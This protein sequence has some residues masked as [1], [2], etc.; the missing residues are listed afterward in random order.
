MSYLA[1]G[2]VTKSIAELLAKKMKP[3]LLGAT[4]PKVTTLPPDDERVD[5][6]D[7]VNLFLY[8]VSEDPYT[9]NMDWRGNRSNAGARHPALSLNLYYLLTGYAK[10]SN[11]SAQDDITAHQLLGNA[12]AI[13]NEYP[14]LNDIHDGDFDADI[15]AQFAK[16]LRDSFERIKISLMPNSMDEFS[17]I[18]TGLS[19]AY[20]LSVTY[21]VSLV[22]IAPTVLSTVNQPS[23]QQVS[24][25]VKA[26][27]APILA[28]ITPSIGT[29]GQQVTLKGKGFLERGLAT[30][31]LI[32]DLRVDETDLVSLSDDQIVLNIPAA[33]QR[34]PRLGISVLVGTNGSEAQTYEV[35]PWIS[36][37]QPLRGL[38]G[39]PLTF[40][41][42]VPSGATIEAAIDGAAVAITVDAEKQVVRAIV[43]PGIVTNGP[44][45]VALILNTKH[46]NV[47]F[48]EVLP[49]ITNV[50]VTTVAA[51]AKTTIELTG[52]RLNGKDIK[53]RYGKLII[54]KDENL[55]AGTLSVDV[56]KRI[57]PTDLPVSV[58][59][60]GRESNV[61]P[62]RLDSIDPSSVFAG[63]EV[64][65]TGSGL[66]G[67]SVSIDFGGTQVN[68]G[69]Q[70]N[71]NRFRVEVPS[72]L[73]AGTVATKLIVNGNDTNTR[74]LV[75][76][77]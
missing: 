13:L 61:L 15:D 35:R 43:P 36:S 70:A 42:E 4:T 54:N 8:R 44:K 46:T 62:P 23:P 52:Q 30:A 34:G 57:L 7:G 73:A 27:G 3:Q 12:M 76:L 53:I 41:F 51:P 74:S 25:A 24:L 17:K 38:T 16:E 58:I 32:D 60:D 21:E 18:W 63:D 71:A 67:S 49:L 6:N 40:A 20:R 26:S 45:P 55:T 50:T 37:I 65:L 72:T 31:V 5:D 59:V 47:R 48:Y 77:G 39:V 10:K 19:K 68:L 22:Q 66:S 2:A 1:I 9:K 11:G 56:D 33:L 64:T 28:S 29:A 75:V 14:V 69:A